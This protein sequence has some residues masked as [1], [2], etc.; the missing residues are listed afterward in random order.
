MIQPDDIRRKAERIYP[1][2]LQSWV[3]GSVETF[4][5]IIIGSKQ[6]DANLATAAQQIQRLRGGSKEVLGYGYSVQWREINSRKFGRNLFPDQ[7]TF[8]TMDDLLRFIKKADE[9]VAFTVA[10]NRIR[11]SLPAL[12]PW[13][14][15]NVRAVVQMSPEI[16]R[17]IEVAGFLKE[18]PQPD[19]FVRELPLSVDTKFIEQHKGVLRQWLDVL[20]PAHTIRA[21]EDHFERRYGLRYAEPQLLVRFLDPILQAQMGFP[22]GVLSLPLHTLSELP[23]QDAKIIIVENK[24]NLL[25]LPQLPGHIGLGGLGRAISLLRYAKFMAKFPVTYWG[26]LDVE[27]FEILSNLRGFCPHAKSLWMDH[28]AIDRWRNLQGVGSGRQPTIPAHL[29]DTERAAYDIC[30][31]KNLRIEQERL[32]QTQVIAALKLIL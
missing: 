6:P 14:R 7:I 9:F 25:T 5:R 2:L 19:C 4:P 12:E 17:L 31:R 29:N 10:I 21:D 23:A 18:H 1:V 26:D 22:C 20:L 15:S 28:A 8:E 11:S 3:Q 24:V 16:E 30:R 32:P 27:G 13:I